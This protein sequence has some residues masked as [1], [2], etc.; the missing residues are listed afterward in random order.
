MLFIEYTRFNQNQPMETLSYND[1]YLQPEFRKNRLRTANY[2][3]NEN[4]I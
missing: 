3:K 4:Y 1:A 2:R